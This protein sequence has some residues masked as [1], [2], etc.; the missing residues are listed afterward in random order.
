MRS[1]IKRLISLNPRNPVIEIKVTENQQF[2][3][4]KK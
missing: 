4:N 1:G 2:L 3:A